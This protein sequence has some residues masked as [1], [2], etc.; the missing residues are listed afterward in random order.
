MDHMRTL[1]RHA[2]CAIVHQ[3][4]DVHAQREP[5]FISSFW[6]YCLYYF[7]INSTLYFHHWSCPLVQL[8][9]RR[10][11]H[12]NK[13]FRMLNSWDYAHNPGVPIYFTST[14]TR[15][16]C[17]V[18]YIAGK[19]SSNENMAA[20]IPRL[21]FRRIVVCVCSSWSHM[22]TQKQWLSR[23]SGGQFALISFPK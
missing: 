14:E 23:A 17:L 9:K 20:E 15:V 1:V 11:R 8:F 16:G 4:G 22:V 10:R 13:F 12:V 3:R 18:H 7:S 19:S 2:D 21:F 6:I 5:S